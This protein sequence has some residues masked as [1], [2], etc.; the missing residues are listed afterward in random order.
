MVSSDGTYFWLNNVQLTSLPANVFSGL[1]S[2]TNLVIRGLL[3]NVELG[4][5]DHLSAMTALWL[6][7]NPQ[8]ASINS[9]LFASLTQLRQLIMVNNN[10]SLLDVST[11]SGLTE[12]TALHIN[13]NRL[14]YLP[15]GIF[16]GLQKLTY[17][18]L[19]NN[20]LTAL[21]AGILIGL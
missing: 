1:K 11:F 12:L 4:A 2:V 17:L 10:I 21:Q 9:L 6:D 8:L 16:S 7:Y 19:N 13:N 15:V 5:L 18:S 14:E 20:P 3:T